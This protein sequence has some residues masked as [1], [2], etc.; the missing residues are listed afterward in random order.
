VIGDAG[1]GKTN[2]I[3][4]FSKEKLPTNIMPTVVVE[5]TSKIIKLNDN[6]VIKA[7]IWDTAG[8]EQYRA[9]TMK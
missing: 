5:F 4:S 7:Q 1:T 8:Q 3:F 6:R 9:L 2:L